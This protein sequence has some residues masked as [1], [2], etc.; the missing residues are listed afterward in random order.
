MP[1]ASRIGATSPSGLR[2]QT[3]PVVRFEPALK[4]V[5]AQF[6]AGADFVAQAID[7]LQRR[8]IAAIDGVAIEDAGVELGDDGL[9]AGGVEGDGGVFA[10]NRSRNCVPPR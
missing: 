1:P 9:D 6:V 3:S 4:D 10:T 5:D 8:K 7:A 2:S